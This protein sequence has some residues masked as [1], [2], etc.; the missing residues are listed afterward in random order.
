MLRGDVC[1]GCARSSYSREYHTP[2]SEPP[3]LPRPLKSPNAKLCTVPNLALQSRVAASFRPA[4]PPSPKGTV[5]HP[6]ILPTSW[7]SA[8]W[9]LRLA[10]TRIRRLPPASRRGGGS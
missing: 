8:P 10:A 1:R 2:P 5:R 6:L 9:F 3:R 4:P 7:L